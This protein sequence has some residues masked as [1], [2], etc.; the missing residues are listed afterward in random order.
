MSLI[1]WSLFSECIFISDISDLGILRRTT[2]LNDVRRSHQT[3]TLRHRC[4]YKLLLI[5]SYIMLNSRCDRWVLSFFKHKIFFTTERH[6][7]ILDIL[8]I[9]SFNLVSW[10]V[11]CEVVYVIVHA[12]LFGESTCQNPILNT[13][14]RI[15]SW[16]LLILKFVLVLCKFQWWISLLV[17]MSHFIIH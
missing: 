7:N 9:E 2:N 13:V 5:F 4:F 17:Q 16:H 15:F 11:H 14:T 6:W 10:W 1:C 8:T 12:V 3:L